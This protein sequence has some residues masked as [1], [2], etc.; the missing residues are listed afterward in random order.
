MVLGA[1]K[2]RDRFRLGRVMREGIHG[3][4]K[5]VYRIRFEVGLMLALGGMILMFGLSRRISNGRR[6]EVE[7]GVYSILTVDLV[8]VTT[9]GGIPRPPDLPQVPIPTEE[10][11]MPED[12]TIEITRL[13][14]TEGIPLFDG[15]GK[16]GGGLGGVGPRPAREV[17]PE[18]PKEVRARG[19]EGVVELAILV[20]HRGG[21]DSVRVLRN[22]TQNKRLEQAAI[23]AAYKSWYFPAQR[24]GKKVSCW[25]QRPY[26]FERR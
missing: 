6:R 17:I 5:A 4:E 20:N 15:T 13:V 12:E 14:L 9:Q 8:P 10:E 22:T 25:I 18:Y 23:Q 24:D 19:V 26:R 21:V 16:R 1:T 11:Y 2:G 3:K 7:R